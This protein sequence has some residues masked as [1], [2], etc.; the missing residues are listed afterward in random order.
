M[1]ARAPVCRL[2]VFLLAVAISSRLVG[3]RSCDSGEPMSECLAEYIEF[4]R[5]AAMAEVKPGENADWLLGPSFATW[6]RNSEFKLVYADEKH[7]SFRALEFAYTGGAH[8]NTRIT[9]GTFDRADGHIVT[10]SELVPD[11]RLPALKTALHDG[12][13]QKVGG[14]E[15]LQQPVVP[16]DNFYID[17]DGLHFVYNEYEIAC[18]ACGAIEVVVPLSALEEN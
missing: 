11:E 18:Y 10:L 12:A 4:C 7:V 5:E 14:Q 16:I 6:E 8:G 3:C 13:A 1:I 2:F 15:N 17:K 9:V